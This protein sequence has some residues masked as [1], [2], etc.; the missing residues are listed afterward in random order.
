MLLFWTHSFPEDL[1]FES[2]L[3]IGCKNLFGYVH[4]IRQ[5]FDPYH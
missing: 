1:V 4:M 2:L 3:D 5:R